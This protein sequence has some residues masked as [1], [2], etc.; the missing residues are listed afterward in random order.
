MQVGE[1]EGGLDFD[2]A[3][4]EG[5]WVGVGMGEVDLHHWCL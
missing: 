4:V 2:F 5:L 1:V 3:V